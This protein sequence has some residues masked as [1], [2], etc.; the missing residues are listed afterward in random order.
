MGMEFTSPIY[1]F[2]FPPATES[3]K[4]HWRGLFP[5]N[6]PEIHLKVVDVTSM[7]D[8]QDRKMELRKRTISLA[9]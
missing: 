7:G 4:N 1:R 2:D 8:L 6:T 3:L 9:I 5:V